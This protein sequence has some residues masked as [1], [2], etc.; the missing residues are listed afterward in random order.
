MK[1]GVL[2]F[3][4]AVLGCAPVVTKAPS[5]APFKPACQDSVSVITGSVATPGGS[6][7]C[8]AG[9]DMHLKVADLEEGVAVLVICSCPDTEI[10]N[11]SKAPSSL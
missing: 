8:E 3:A 1:L 11:D 2:A 5:C 6:A 4:A 7:K 10:R 9:Q